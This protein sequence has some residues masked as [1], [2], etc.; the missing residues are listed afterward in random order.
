MGRVRILVMDDEFYVRDAVGEM[1]LSI[2]FDVELAEDGTNAIARYMNAI[3]K[4]CPFDIVIMD[5]T[6]E[7]GMGGKEAVRKILEIDPNAKAIVASGNSNDTVMSDCTNYGFKAAS[8]VGYM[9]VWTRLISKYPEC[10]TN[11]RNSSNSSSAG[12]AWGWPYRRRRRRASW[13]APPPP[14]SWASN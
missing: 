12:R 6:I 5:L 9:M 1:L 11:I 7:D 3:D 4:G 2:G 14:W 13:S 10:W 8:C